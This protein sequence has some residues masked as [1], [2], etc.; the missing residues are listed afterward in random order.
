VFTLFDTEE[1]TEEEIEGE[2]VDEARDRLASRLAELEYLAR[3]VADLP[4]EV[5][6]AAQGIVHADSDGWDDGGEDDDRDDVDDWDPT[7]CDRCEEKLDPNDEPYLDSMG[8]QL[9]VTCEVIVMEG[10]S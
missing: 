2:S 3:S 5:D 7:T 10:F 1:E 6:E 4:V 9:C 8:R